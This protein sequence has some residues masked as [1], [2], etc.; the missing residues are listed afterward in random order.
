MSIVK[1]FFLIV[2]SHKITAN[3]RR[4]QSVENVIYIPPTVVNCIQGFPVTNMTKHNWRK[5]IYTTSGT[6]VV[7]LAV[8]HHDHFS[9]CTVAKISL[10]IYFLLRSSIFFFL[11][12]VS[13]YQ[14]FFYHGNCLQDFSILRKKGIHSL[15]ISSC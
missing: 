11:I 5:N 8:W 6:A 13:M 12:S 1:C 2:K 3:K 15:T 4:T 10:W 9:W 7:N 14:F